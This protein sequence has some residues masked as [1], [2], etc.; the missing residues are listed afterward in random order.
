MIRR[1]ARACLPLLAAASLAACEG[2]GSG[3]FLSIGT[4]GT[5]G[6]YYPLGGALASRLSERDTT[7]QYTAEVTGG[8]V[9][10]VNRVAQGQIDLGFALAVTAYEAYHGGLGFDSAVTSLR[11]IAP[12]YPNVGHAAVR[13]TKRAAPRDCPSC[14]S[15]WTLTPNAATSSVGLQPVGRHSTR[16]CISHGSACCKKTP[17]RS[18]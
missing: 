12:L 15:A 4:G 8:S 14:R 6:V 3:R 2:G 10:N 18:W 16:R 7:R 11:V 17:I 5:G 13:Y 9:E 1:L